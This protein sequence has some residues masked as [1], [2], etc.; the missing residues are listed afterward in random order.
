MRLKNDNDNDKH[1]EELLYE[2]NCI[3]NAR[4]GNKSNDS[5]KKLYTIARGRTIGIFTKWEDPGGAPES[6]FGYKNNYHKNF[7]NVEEA[8]RFIE[9]HMTK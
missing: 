8:L 5:S 1:L 6:V 2:L 4:K 7:Y 9:M 3:L